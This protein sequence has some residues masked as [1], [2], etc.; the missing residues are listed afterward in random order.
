MHGAGTSLQQPVDSN[1]D[2]YGPASTVSS[3]LYLCSIVS[4]SYI[5]TWLQD[6]HQTALGTL[7]LVV[8]RLQIKA[9]A[10]RTVRG[11]A[12]TKDSW[13]RASCLPCAPS[14]RNSCSIH[15]ASILFALRAS[16]L[17]ILLILAHH[18]HSLTSSV[19]SYMDQFVVEAGNKSKTSFLGYTYP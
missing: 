2:A 4:V 11:F 14:A 13:G 9:V 12:T 8:E 6:S 17:S 19:G 1:G 5:L 15:R 18:A 3:R 7:S 16:C 10:L